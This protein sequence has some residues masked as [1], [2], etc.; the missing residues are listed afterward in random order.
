VRVADDAD[1]RHAAQIDAFFA[2]AESL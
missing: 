1:A 2:H